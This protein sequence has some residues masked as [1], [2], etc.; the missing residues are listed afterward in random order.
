MKKN[1]GI[2]SR[3]EFAKALIPY[4]G[5]W[6][7]TKRTVDLLRS[8]LYQN[9]SIETMAFNRNVTMERV[10]QMLAK[11]QRTLGIAFPED[12]YCLPLSLEDRVFI[13]NLQKLQIVINQELSSLGLTS[14]HIEEI[15][16][17]LINV[18]IDIIEERDGD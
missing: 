3:E 2:A 14:D 4:E 1:N 7:F 16:V 11:A 10:R 9:E 18:T 12:D 13:Y 8:Y 15:S 5:K 17:K 6:P